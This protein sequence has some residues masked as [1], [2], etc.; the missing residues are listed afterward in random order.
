V[1]EHASTLVATAEPPPPTGEPARLSRRVTATAIDFLLLAAALLWV[2]FMQITIGDPAEVGW[3]ALVWVVLVT[4]L[5]FALYHAYGTGATPGQRELGVAVRG[6]DGNARIRLRAALLRSY[7]APLLFVP[8]LRD[9]VTRSRVVTLEP[10]AEAPAPSA[11]VPTVPELAEIFEPVGAGRAVRRAVR[12]VWT[13][14]GEFVRSVLVLYLGLVGL[15]AVVAPLFI[16]DFS[17][18]DTGSFE[19]VF[20][21]LV[22]VALFASGVYWKQAT[23]STAVEAI[24][25]GERIGAGEILRRTARRVNGLT[26]A[27]VLLLACC[28]MGAL[29]G[30]IPLIFLPYALAR[31]IFVVPAIA[32]EDRHVLAAFRRSIRLTEKHAWRRTGTLIVSGLATGLVLLVAGTFGIGLATG[33]WHPPSTIGYA[34]VV[35]A[36]LALA[37][38]PVSL[39]LAVIGTTWAL[40]YYD[41]VRGKA[42]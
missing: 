7:V 28:A 14:R 15:A 23:I 37:S 25:A 9:R 36:G 17:A 5:F 38:L 16:E 11:R 29:L 3:L 32:I 6:A 26:V 27:L 33:L 22:A 40:Y 10:L 24:R 8:T 20:W 30:G 13:H 35:A 1:T 19:A 39:A 18:S 4:P 34:F 31:C 12:L 21:T 2:V 41:L 42:A